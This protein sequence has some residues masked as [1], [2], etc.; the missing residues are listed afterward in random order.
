MVDV[1]MME[2]DLLEAYMVTERIAKDLIQH[3]N[4]QRE[5]VD[6]YHQLNTNHFSSDDDDDV[7]IQVEQQAL[8][9]RMPSTDHFQYIKASA[10]TQIVDEISDPDSDPKIL[11]F[12]EHLD[13]ELNAISQRMASSCNESVEESEEE[14]NAIE[15]VMALVDSSRNQ[16]I[17][18]SRPI[19]IDDDDAS[20]PGPLS[21]SQSHAEV[22][23][24][25]Q[26]T[27]LLHRDLPSSSNHLPHSQPAASRS[28][29]L[30]LLLALRAAGIDGSADDDA[31]E[32][33][34]ASFNLIIRAATPVL[35]R[36][37]LLR[38]LAITGQP[39]RD[40]AECG[41]ALLAAAP[42][43]PNP[44]GNAVRAAIAAGDSARWDVTTLAHALLRSPLVARTSDRTLV[45]A[46]VDLRNRV[47]HSVG[48]A[49]L[50][51]TLAEAHAAA[52]GQIEELARRCSAPPAGGM[53]CPSRRMCD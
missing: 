6:P 1:E 14:R 7:Y 33:Q 23:G 13:R 9:L 46:I 48:S 26:H 53:G 34:I 28:L 24:C 20:P 35:R 16:G 27:N 5:A 49:G 47:C 15:Q 37:F 8:K 29:P 10:S 12:L 31:A 3:I 25:S 45:S 43:R 39:W 4:T 11:N 32:I 40:T 30:N 41:Q 42:T 22:L 18:K 50:G 51:D 2:P 19:L 44:S 52:A 36:F 21:P 17:S 38:W